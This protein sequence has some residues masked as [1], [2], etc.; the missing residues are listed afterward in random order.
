MGP[1]IP[2]VYS[3]RIPCIAWEVIKGSADQ[4]PRLVVAIHLGVAGN[5]AFAIAYDTEMRLVLQ[6]L[7]RW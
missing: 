4:L 1:L 7:A 5:G 3:F 6:R 2:E